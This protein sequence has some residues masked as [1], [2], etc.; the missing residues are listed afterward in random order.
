VSF[1][2]GLAISYQNL[3]AT[4]SSLD[5]LDKALVFFEEYNKLEKELYFA[6]PTNVSF[7]N[8]LASSYAHLGIFSKN[9]FKDTTKART[10]LQQAEALWQELVRD[11]PQNVNYQAFLG[12]VQKELEDL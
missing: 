3:G 5:N 7:K 12:V 9:N 2:N 10:Y 8:N 1:K 4:H 6:Y 11:T